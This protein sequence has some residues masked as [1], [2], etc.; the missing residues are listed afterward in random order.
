MAWMWWLLA[1]VASTLTG[2]ALL[3]WRS[4]LE[5]GSP[6]RSSAAMREHQAVLQTLSRLQ[7][8]DTMPVTMRVLEPAPAD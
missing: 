1:P 2:A 6:S 4:W 5:P 3:W 8:A 7:P